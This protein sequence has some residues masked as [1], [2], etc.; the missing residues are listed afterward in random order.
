[1]VNELVAKGFAGSLD[2]DEQDDVALVSGVKQLY[3][4]TTMAKQLEAIEELLLRLR[5]LH[6]TGSAPRLLA[7]CP[8]VRLTQFYAEHFSRAGWAISSVHSKM[9]AAVQE[10]VT[11]CF[12]RE[13]DVMFASDAM[14]SK[15]GSV[16][17]CEAVVHLGLPSSVKEYR[18]R[19][20]HCISGGVAHLIIC[21]FEEACCLR[22]FSPGLQR[23]PGAPAHIEK[24]TRD[25]FDTNSPDVLLKVYCSWLGYYNSHLKRLSCTRE[26]LVRHAARFAVEALNLALPP[27]LEPRLVGM[28]ALKGVEGI[29]VANGKPKVSPG[30]PGSQPGTQHHQKRGSGGAGRRGNMSGARGGGGGRGN[31][32]GSM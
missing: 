12:S 15:D 10:H 7:F 14:T 21:D 17:P 19:L 22:E 20:R 31:A 6:A 4:V 16:T 30:R 2:E 24:R 5:G 27:A 9:P 11:G 18:R 13:G 8:T 32:T 26:E 1:M 25:D 23:D 28:M 3:S 29:V